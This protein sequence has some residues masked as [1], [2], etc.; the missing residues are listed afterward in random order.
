M[1]TDYFRPRE[2]D[3]TPI[4]STNR[5]KKRPRIKLIE[6][7]NGFEKRVLGFKLPDKERKR[8]LKRLTVHA[9]HTARGLT[10]NA[11]ENVGDEAYFKA[12]FLKKYQ[13][14]GKMIDDHLGPRAKSL[15]TFYQEQKHHNYNVY[16]EAIIGNFFAY[17]LGKCFHLLPKEG[18]H[19]ALASEYMEKRYK[20]AAN[21]RTQKQTSTLVILE[22]LLKFI[23]ARWPNQKI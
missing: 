19:P 20:I 2:E 11:R 16:K 4:I 8:L 15:F 10:I 22:A 3:N 21:D 1:I 9:I 23:H 5:E 13:Q 7:P 18:K 14:A 6:V 12:I 17:I